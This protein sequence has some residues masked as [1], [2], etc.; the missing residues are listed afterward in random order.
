MRTQYFKQFFFSLKD[1]L[2]NRID[3]CFLMVISLKGRIL[4]YY[5]YLLM[6]TFLN[7]CLYDIDGSFL[8][9]QKTT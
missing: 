9:A 6:I 4:E 7:I 2:N 8:Q 1:E 5:P 3:T